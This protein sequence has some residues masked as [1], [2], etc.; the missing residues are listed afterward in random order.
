MALKA[1]SET[2]EIAQYIRRDC[3]EISGVKPNAQLAAKVKSA[4]FKFT[5]FCL[6]S[7]NRWLSQNTSSYYQLSKIGIQRNVAGFNTELC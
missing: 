3:L 6:N 4:K 5:Q 7:V 1:M 2:H